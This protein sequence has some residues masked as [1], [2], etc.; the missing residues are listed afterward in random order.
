MRISMNC[1]VW[2][3][4]EIQIQPEGGAILNIDS[5]TA[6]KGLKIEEI[7]KGKQNGVMVWGGEFIGTIPYATGT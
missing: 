5:F 7:K 6:H 3:A 1:V 4:S 2:A